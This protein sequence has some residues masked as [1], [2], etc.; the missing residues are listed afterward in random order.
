MEDF[1]IS[2]HRTY[3]HVFHFCSW[4]LWYHLRG[5]LAMNN[6]NSKIIKLKLF[7]PNDKANKN[8]NAKLSTLLKHQKEANFEKGFYNV[9]NLILDSGCDCI[10]IGY[11]RRFNC[12][13]S[14]FNNNCLIFKTCKVNE[15]TSYLESQGYKWQ[16]P[17]LM[18]NDGITVVELIED[19]ISLEK[20]YRFIQ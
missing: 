20:H 19:N 6:T 14:I 7:N 17:F 10:R 2:L 5:N 8:F 18:L 3:Y 9:C 15:I 12:Y 4:I 1:V 13:S 11:D 16:P